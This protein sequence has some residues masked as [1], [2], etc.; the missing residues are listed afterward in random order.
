MNSETVM[1]QVSWTYNPEL[2]TVIGVLRTEPTQMAFMMELKN[3]FV[4]SAFIVDSSKRKWRVRANAHLAGQLLNYRIGQKIKLTG[5]KG[6]LCKGAWDN[7]KRQIVPLTISVVD[8]NKRRLAKI[9]A[10]NEAS[11]TTNRV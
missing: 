7:A 2:G 10:M 1:M 6:D 3:E 4:V 8:E 11:L 9:T 5:V